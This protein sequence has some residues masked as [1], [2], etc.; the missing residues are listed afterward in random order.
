MSNRFD[1]LRIALAVTTATALVVALFTVLG[2][3]PAGAEHVAPDDTVP[4]SSEA[5]GAA[6][7]EDYL[8]D[9]RGISGASCEKIGESGGNTAFVMPPEPDGRVWVLLAVKQ[10][11]S[12]HVYYDPIAGHA[13][14]SVGNQA[15]GV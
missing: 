13:Y 6:F 5:N 7:W 8:V 12:N 1:G 9:V 11:T 10:A 2:A 15:P 14:P 4:H 3:F